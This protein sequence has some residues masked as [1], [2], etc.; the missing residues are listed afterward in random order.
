MALIN[1]LPWREELRVQRRKHFGWALLLVALLVLF[2]VL[3]AD[4]Y[5]DRR[6]DHQMHRNQQISLE[7]TE[8]DRRIE[9]L[10]I[11]QRQRHS[12]LERVQVVEALHTRRSLSA[13][14]LDQLARG[15][16]DGVHFTH[17]TLTGDKLGIRGLAASNHQVAGLL[18][19]LEASPWL[20]A[21]NLTQIRRLSADEGQTA[22]AFQM[23]VERVRHTVAQVAQ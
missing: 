1:L 4:R 7:I 3:I 21:A 15:V 10:A 6:I 13:R 23:T 12:L 11:L 9:A 14:M 2:V 19:N 20:Q 18:R 17:V 8:L 5:T 22:S 16:P